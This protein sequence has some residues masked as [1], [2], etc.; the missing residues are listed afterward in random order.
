MN[1]RHESPYIFGIHEPG[2]EHYMAQFG[3]KSW[4]VFTEALGTD[5]ND[6][7]GRDY[8]PW[9]DA[10]FSVIVRLNNGYNPVGTIPFPH[11][12]E[13]FAVR[14]AN[15]VRASY[16]CHIW[17]IGN[18][19]NNQIEW[20]GAFALRRQ[21]TGIRQLEEQ[22]GRVLSL[23]RALPQRFNA[24][25]TDLP[26]V[27][28]ADQGD[29]ITPEKYTRC[30]RR[31]RSAIK[32]IAG[33]TDDQVLVGAVT[34]WNTHT[35]YAGNPFGD[36]VQ[37]QTD[38]L[39]EL[40]P[41]GCDGLAIHTYTHGAD[42]VLI[43]DQRHM[44]PPFQHRYY[45]FYTYRDFMAGIPANMQHLPV[46]IT[47]MDQDDPWRDANSGWVQ[48]AYAEIDRW[49]RQPNHQQI[50][51]AVLYRWPAIDQWVIEGKEGVIADFCAALQNDYRWNANAGPAAG[52]VAPKIQLSAAEFVRGQQVHVVSTINVRRSPGASNKGPDDIIGQLSAGATATIVAG[53]TY[54]DNLVWWQARSEI[55][56]KPVEG[57]LAQAVA[58]DRPLLLPAEKGDYSFSELD[59]VITVHPIRLRRTP[60]QQGKGVEDI[61]TILPVNIRASVLG[62][63]QRLDGVIWWRVRARHRG[64]S[65]T[66]WLPETSSNGM[67]L[68]VKAPTSTPGIR[69]FSIDPALRPGD[70]AYAN[71]FINLRRSPGYVGKTIDDIVV[72][73]PYGSSVT[74][75]EGP[76]TSDD[77]TWWQ[78][79]TLPTS[80]R[81]EQG[82]TAE[83]TASGQ[84]LLTKKAPPPPAIP[85]SPQ[86]NTYKPGDAVCNISQAEVNIRS[87]PGYRDK[88]T[89]DIVA[90]VASKALLRLVDGPREVDGLLWW[91]V[92]GQSGGQTIEGW[93]AEVA[94][95]GTRLLAPALMRNA[96]VLSIPYQGNQRVSQLWGDNPAFYRQ[97]TYDGV[98]LRGHNGIDFAMPIGTPLRATDNGT[99][100]TVGASPSGFGNWVML[101]HRWGQSVYAHMHKVTVREGQPVRRHGIIG[102]SGN[103]GTS[104]GPH[105]HFSIRINPHYRGDGWGGYC[106]PLPFL[107]ADKLNI[108]SYIRGEGP[109]E[110]EMLP[111]PPPI[112]EPGRPLP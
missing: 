69:A 110:P 35:R 5:P 24:L 28:S 25:H 18:E 106:D 42:P 67:A 1:R 84:P 15:F 45:H 19:M 100:L 68:I 108:P 102:E 105:L 26:H 22:P 87:T 3:R 76:Q 43:H 95:T 61:V 92:K 111:S 13:N 50:R 32:G 38:I 63:P 34:P 20:P 74:I 77:L 21:I 112:E 103:S 107:D 47:E 109:P 37:Y 83:S 4:I 99:V 31:C 48:Q 40:G 94:P 23:L 104:T 14:C 16:G 93:M 71:S 73:I 58:E 33:H 9:S 101:D 64:K 59:Q 79:K 44:D 56:A 7:S 96:I 98:P 91:H 78:V 12:Y 36:W 75:V 85:R 53:P 39:E 70:T 11:E 97:F 62:T 29:P 8:R 82:W 86:V 60:G 90:R 89:S 66:G 30:Y 88:P 46:Y 52:F 2:G 6:Q 80:G 17:I 54:R 81:Q 55:D 51:A 65:I 27:R 72:E 10:G 41:E 49:N 57:W